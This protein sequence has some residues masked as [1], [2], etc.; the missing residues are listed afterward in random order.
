MHAFVT[1]C[2]ELAMRLKVVRADIQQKQHVTRTSTVSEP[3]N[4]LLAVVFTVCVNALSALHVQG[5]GKA[6]GQH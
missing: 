6:Q 5:D 4:H 3:T 1:H 2:R